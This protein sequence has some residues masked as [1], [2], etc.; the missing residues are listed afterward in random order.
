M[1]KLVEAAGGD[2]APL[3]S[4][5]KVLNAALTGGDRNPSRVGMREAVDRAFDRIDTPDLSR[6]NI[7]ELRKILKIENG[8]DRVKNSGVS[9]VPSGEP[10]KACGRII[11]ALAQRR[12]HL[13]P[14]GEMEDLVPAV[15]GHGAPWVGAVLEGQFH[16]STDSDGARE[17]MG[18]V[19]D[20]LSEREVEV[21]GQ[22]E[23]A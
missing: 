20:S 3:E 4:D 6:K 14:V 9:A 23:P 22:H 12:I 7:E 11:K 17:L 10:Y 5:W 2:P 13:V 15:G 16:T 19:L 21:P 1:S 18:R 8:W